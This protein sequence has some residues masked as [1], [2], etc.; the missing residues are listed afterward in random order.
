[1]WKGSRIRRFAEWIRMSIYLSVCLCVCVYLCSCICLSVGVFPHKWSDQNLLNVFVFFLFL[2]HL[3]YS[4]FLLRFCTVLD[5]IS[6]KNGF[7][8]FQEEYVKNPNVNRYGTRVQSYHFKSLQIFLHTGL[9]LIHVIFTVFRQ[10]LT[11]YVRMDG[12]LWACLA[13]R[14]CVCLYSPNGSI[15]FVETCHKWSIKCYWIK[16][17]HIWLNILTSPWAIWFLVYFFKNQ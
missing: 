5:A 6:F 10:I 13:V 14:V 16:E 2:F 11:H 3:V 12:C 9:H 7:D 15:S 8:I 1:M 4:Y 17:N